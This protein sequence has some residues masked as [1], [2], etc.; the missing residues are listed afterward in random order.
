MP[1]AQKGISE[2]LVGRAPDT[3][4]PYGGGGARGITQVN[5]DPYRANQIIPGAELDVNTIAF[6]EM[7]SFS[8]F[9]KE[10]DVLQAEEQSGCDVC[11][12]A[13][14]GHAG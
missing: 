13:T 12:P 11:F 6:G 5:D 9:E 7:D 10:G 1:N 2:S 8:Q 4:S 14:G 3:Q